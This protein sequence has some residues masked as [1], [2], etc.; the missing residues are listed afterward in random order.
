M[1]TVG[2]AAHRKKILPTKIYRRS[3]LSVRV[4]GTVWTC[5]IKERNTRKYEY[6][7]QLAT[8]L[9]PFISFQIHEPVSTPFPQ[10]SSRL[11]LVSLLSIC[12]FLVSPSVAPSITTLG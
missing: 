11:R 6:V 12:I 10:F 3:A 4:H 5:I 1:P 8:Y 7:I 9:A 2:H